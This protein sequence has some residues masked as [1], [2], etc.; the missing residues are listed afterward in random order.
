MIYSFTTSPDQ[1]L[2]QKIIL[3]YAFDDWQPLDIHQIDIQS[4][5]S[6]AKEKQNLLKWMLIVN[7]AVNLIT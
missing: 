3:T 4:I 6:Q 1:T 5:Q 2:S 7:L